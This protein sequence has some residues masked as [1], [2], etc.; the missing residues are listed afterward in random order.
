MLLSENITNYFNSNQAR[1]IHEIEAFLGSLS[2]TYRDVSQFLV[3]PDQLQYGRYTLYK[4]E[5]VE[6]CILHWVKDS[7][8][9]IHD[10]ADS[11]CTMLVIHGELMN[12]DYQLNEKNKLIRAASSRFASNDILSVSKSD[13]HEISQI[14][15]EFSVSLH[16]YYPPIQ[17]NNIFN[18]N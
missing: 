17:N 7:R 13:I 15:T 18:A 1:S 6:V 4:N 14:G 5:Q 12:E 8:S 9:P 3:P 10:H 16:V 2:L 11:D